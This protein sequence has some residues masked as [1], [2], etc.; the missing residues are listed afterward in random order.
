MLRHHNTP[1]WSIKLRV[2]SNLDM[3]CWFFHHTVLVPPTRRVQP[4]KEDFTLNYCSSRFWVLH[5][6]EEEFVENTP[7]INLVDNS[8]KDDQATLNK[9]KRTSAKEKT[10]GKRKT[11]GKETSSC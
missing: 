1:C 10:S 9:R 11:S 6:S 8:E 5:V 3:P 7:P 2:S 4:S